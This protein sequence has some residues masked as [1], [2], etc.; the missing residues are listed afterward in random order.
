VKLA[1]FGVAAKHEDGLDTQANSVVG[2][3]YWM[4]PEIIQMTGFTTAADIWSLG[5]TIVELIAGE[6]PYADLPP[7][8]ALFRIV[9]EQ[10][11]TTLSAPRVP[12]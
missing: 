9:N 7:M 11:H 6:P 2:T 3:P 8:A 1:D 4:A 12:C 10:V 5:C